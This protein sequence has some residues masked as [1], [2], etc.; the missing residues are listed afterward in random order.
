[1]QK[2]PHMD[3]TTSWLHSVNS[4]FSILNAVESFLCSQLTISVYIQSYVKLLILST[5]KLMIYKFST[6][7]VRADDTAGS[8]WTWLIYK[9][10]SDPSS[11]L[12]TEACSVSPWCRLCDCVPTNPGHHELF[13][14]FT[15]TVPRWGLAE[16]ESFRDFWNEPQILHIYKVLGVADLS[17]VPPEAMLRWNQETS[18]LWHKSYSWWVINNTGTAHVFVSHLYILNA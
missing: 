2:K 7:T 13:T 1:M 12:R 14:L 3:K 17:V 4:D 11:P 9:F 10:W 16:A 15:L 5:F 18:V 8:L 6:F